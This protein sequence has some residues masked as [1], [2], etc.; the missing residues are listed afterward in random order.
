[1]AL[2]ADLTR[3]QHR[4]K[5]MAMIGA[6][7]GLTF[8]LSLVGAPILYRYI[9]MGGVFALTGCLRLLAIGVVKY[10]VPDEP[11]PPA[12]VGRRELGSLGGHSSPS[13]CA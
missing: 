3:E 4:T 5:I 13:C 12:A 11:P 10:W 2:A 1:M 6:T 8:A 7:I 9:G